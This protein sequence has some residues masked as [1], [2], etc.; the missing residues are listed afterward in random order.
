MDANVFLKVLAVWWLFHV[1]VFCEECHSLLGIAS[2]QLPY[3]AHRH[4]V[5]CSRLPTMCALSLPAGQSDHPHLLI[6]QTDTLRGKFMDKTVVG[7]AALVRGG[8]YTFKCERTDG[9]SGNNLRWV[10]V[11][12]SR[13]LQ[14]EFT[15]NGSILTLDNVQDETTGLYRCED[16]NSMDDMEELLLSFGMCDSCCWCVCV[17]VIAGV[18]CVCGSRT[19]PRDSGDWLWLGSMRLR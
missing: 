18:V 5:H 8:G 16:G 3:V 10:Y 17:C 4:V 6:K 1:W 11:T 12:E 7:I 13:S 2:Q 19:F 14:Q 9:T 15:N